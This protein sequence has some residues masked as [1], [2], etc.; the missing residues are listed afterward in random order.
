MILYMDIYIQ[1]FLHRRTLTPTN[2]Q[3]SPRCNLHTIEVIYPRYTAAQKT[4]MRHAVMRLARSMHYNGC[5][6]AIKYMILLHRFCLHWQDGSIWASPAVFMRWHHACSMTTSVASHLRR[7]QCL[8]SRS[9]LLG[10]TWRQDQRQ[11][12]L[13][14][15]FLASCLSCESWSCPRARPITRR[16][17]TRE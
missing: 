3:L 4:G 14:G 13:G 1:P 10:A 2:S 11:R 6:F 12:P 15:A 16:G 8:R 17:R 7:G 9:C 5:E